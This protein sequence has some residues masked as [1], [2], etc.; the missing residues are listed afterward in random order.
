MS[1]LKR[2]FEYGSLN[3]FWIEL[4]DEYP[5][6]AKKVILTLLLFVTTYR[7][8]A[9]FSFYA[10]NN[11]NIQNIQK[12]ETKEVGINCWVI[13]GKSASLVESWIREMIRNF[14]FFQ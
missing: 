7:Y 4:R 10:Y 1:S 6:L 11:A 3:E 13:L 14:V 5:S 2:K 12:D 8:K 9:G